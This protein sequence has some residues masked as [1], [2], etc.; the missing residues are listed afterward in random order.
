MKLLYIVQEHDDL[1]IISH[2]FNTTPE[3]IHKVNNF[4]KFKE[5]DLIFIP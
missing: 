2:K 3:E 1:N 4:D 5:G